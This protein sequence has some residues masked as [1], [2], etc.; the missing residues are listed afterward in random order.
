MHR[1]PSHRSPPSSRPVELQRRI[2][3]HNTHT[4][5]VKHAL[6]ADTSARQIRILRSTQ[7]RDDETSV[8]NLAGSVQ[9]SL[10]S[11]CVNAEQQG[12]RTVYEQQG[13]PRCSCSTRRR[14][15]GVCEEESVSRGAPTHTHM[16]WTVWTVSCGD[17][18]THLLP[19]WC[20]STV[21]GAPRHRKRP[22]QPWQ[23]LLYEHGEAWV[24]YQRHGC[25]CVTLSASPGA[26]VPHIHSTAGQL[27][28]IGCTAAMLMLCK[29]CVRCQNQFHT[30]DT[31]CRP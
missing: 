9:W 18:S 17:V 14:W 23:H 16:V 7:Q 27:P 15:L 11:T 10:T 29:H 5:D 24:R 21:A 1:P 25:I 13:W 20:R 31:R 6:A 19:G 3:R 2:H 28:Q 8:V 26:A 22:A 30:H 12:H 4:R